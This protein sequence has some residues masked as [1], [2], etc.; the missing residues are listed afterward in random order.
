MMNMQSKD[1]LMFRILLNRFHPKTSELFLKNMPQEEARL[2][3]NQKLSSTDVPSLLTQPESLI[4]KVHY[5]WLLDTF[6]KI[7]KDLHASILASIPE[8]HFKGLSQALKIPE[9]KTNL[10]PIAK[11]FLIN[12]LYTQF[13][14]KEIL[15]LEFLPENPL[16]FLCSLRKQ[17]LVTLIDYLGIYDLAEEIRHIVEK[18]LLKDIYSCIPLKKQQFL[19]SCLNQK[20][21]LVTPR[22]DLGNWDRDSQKLEKILHKRG[23]IRLSHALSGLHPDFVWHLTHILDSG[24]GRIIASHYKEEEIPSVSQALIMQ[25]INVNNY[26]N[27]TSEP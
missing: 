11:R 13:E 22:L 16:L 10:S 14:K 23:M 25:V 2:V 27:K 24:R 5:S 17:Q 7:P 19:K 12:M 4:E 1:W 21:K 18:N 3:L 6:N 9:K 20:E 8:V 26:L 15:P